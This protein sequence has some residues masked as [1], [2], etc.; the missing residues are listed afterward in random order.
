MCGRCDS[1]PILP[2]LLLFALLLVPQL[3]SASQWPTN[4]RVVIENTEPLKWPRSGRLPLFVLPISGSLASLADDEATD[5]LEQLD[6]RGI[7]YSVDWNHN[8]FERSLA[9]GIRIGRIQKRLGQ[10]IA[11]N[12]NACLYSFCDG[13]EE[14]LHVDANGE[15]FAETSFGGRLGC[16]FALEHRIPVIKERVEKF[17]RAYQEQGLRIGFVFADWEIDGPIEW[18]DAWNTCRKCQRCRNAIP[19]IDD[20]RAFQSRLREIRSRLQLISFGDNVTAYFPT[21]LVGNYGTYPHNGYRYWYDYF[22]EEP[23]SDA[24]PV[25]KDQAAKYR[26][27]SHEFDDTGYTFAM[28]VVYTWYR[29]FD[30]YDFAETDYR[31]FYNM[32]LV[33]S[34]A[35]RYTDRSTPIIPFVHWTTT[36]PPKEPEA[37]VKQFGRGRY[38]ELLWHLLLRGH[39]TFFLWCM[40][41]ELKEEIRLVHEV[42]AASLEHGGFLNRGTSISYDVPSQ[43]GSVVS[44]L[45][46]G[47]RVLIRRTD[48]EERGQEPIRIALEDG[49][50]VV[51]PPTPGL[52]LASATLPSQRTGF[53]NK[54][55]KTLFPIGMYEM[56]TDDDA[57]KAMSAA[58]INL[59]LC[60]DRAALDRAHAVG[61]QGWKPLG[62]PQGATEGLRKQIEAV[63]DHPALAVWEGPDEIIWTFTAYS[64][65]KDRAGFT[66]DDWNDQ[67]KIAVDYA[68]KNAK[69]IMPAMRDAVKLIRELDD[70]QRPVWINEAADSDVGFARQYMPFIDITGCDYYAVRSTGTDL[71]SI[72]RLVNR[73]DAIGDGKPVWMVLQAFSWHSIKPERGRLYPS[74]AQ[75]RFMAYDAIVH[76]AKGVL[77][78]GSNMIDDPKFRESL[79]A[80][81]SELSALQP[82][83]TGRSIEGVRA[84]VIDDLFDPPGRGVRLL[85]LEDAHDYMLV[86]VNEDDHRHLGV[87]VQG[88]QMLNGRE[89]SLLYGDETTRVSAGRLVTRMQPF[90]VKLLATN[91]AKYESKRTAGREYK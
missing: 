64:F 91:K 81:T 7:G 34:N 11:V 84:N 52:H 38:Q 6:Q 74:F 60:G 79:Y 85:L 37:H 8:D 53:I 3:A 32:L 19:Q 33:G 58:G 10:P 51:V 80:L 29:T 27:W 77:Y 82:L 20:F 83:L 40:G 21:A 71:Q 56:P 2:W 5:A 78:W 73:W 55:G 57:L 22:E 30:W 75:S 61:M 89:L 24:I 76:G 12:A 88:L 39:D 9:E 44:G 31:W 1:R 35:G 45:R 72:G 59:V 41:P 54:D 43:P 15:R 4:L 18:N 13:S 23:T 17:L 36:A 66:R 28:P 46:L 90:E 47:D 14:T 65:L 25:R 63:K 68:E 67:K 87:E 26:E 69:R 70:H 62:L 48:F 50:E 86:L 42:Y 49:K 16:P